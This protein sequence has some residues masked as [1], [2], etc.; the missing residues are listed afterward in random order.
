MPS[1]SFLQLEFNTLQAGLITANA[2]GT[3]TVRTAFPGAWSR[4]QS[5][6]GARDGGSFVQ[7]RDGRIDVTLTAAASVSCDH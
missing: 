2:N 7:N 1:P 3:M 6:P 5:G 4:G